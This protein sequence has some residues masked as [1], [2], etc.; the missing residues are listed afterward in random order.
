MADKIDRIE[1]I[2]N[3]FFAKIKEEN[4]Q[5]LKSIEEDQSNCDHVFNILGHPMPLNMLQ[6]RRCSKCNYT[7]IMTT[8]EWKFQK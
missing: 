8:T 4:E 2:R 3:A 7:K 5:K 1:E 6:S